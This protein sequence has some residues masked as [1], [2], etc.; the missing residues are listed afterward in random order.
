MAD[1]T[2]AIVPLDALAQIED[3]LDVHR[4][5]E[6]WEADGRKIDTTIAIA[7]YHQALQD[8]M[9]VLRPTSTLVPHHGEKP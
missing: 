7:F 9:A 2:S 3:G 8:A 5:I 1:R 4:W 6:L